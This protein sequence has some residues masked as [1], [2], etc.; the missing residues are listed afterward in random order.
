MLE[1]CKNGLGILQRWVNGGHL[2]DDKINKWIISFNPPEAA[3]HSSNPLFHYS[4]LAAETQTSDNIQYF[5]KII[6]IQKC[7]I[8]IWNSRLVGNIV[9]F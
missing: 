5:H 4:M 3:H 1:H 8:D 6:E 2:L 7:L 9:F